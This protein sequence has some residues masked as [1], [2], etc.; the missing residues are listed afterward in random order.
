MASTKSAKAQERELYGPSIT[1]VV[2]GATLSLL[3]GALLG[4]AHLV[5][6]PVESVRVLPDEPALNQVYY[7]AG[8][9]SGG[10]QWLRKKQMLVEGEDAD[11]RLSEGELNKWISSAKAKPDDVEAGQIFTT[12]GVNFRIAED[13]LQVGIP[14]D[15]S[16]AG[17]SRSVII[18]TE[19]VFEPAGD[20]FRYQPDRLMIGS[21]AVHKLPII[22]SL[23]YSRLLAS[24]ELGDDVITAWNS[25]SSVSIEGNTLV[26][27]RL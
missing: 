23:V 9:N 22:S 25:L 19:G 1:E 5:T 20:H 16:V 18:Q 27:K 3:I 24:Q 11:L 26:L 4:A 7:V 14:A 15:F 8:A 10:G 6:K 12:R 13:R 17:F 2:I 21:L